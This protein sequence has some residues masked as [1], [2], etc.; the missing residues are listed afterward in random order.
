M[1]PIC[2]S[3]NIKSIG[4]INYEAPIYYSSVEIELSNQPELWC[5]DNCKSWFVQN[6]VSQ[7]DSVQLY[8]EGDASDRWGDNLFE[9]NHAED[10][11]KIISRYL[12]KGKTLLDIGCCDG[13]FLDYAHKK[14][15]ITY[16]IEYSENA[17][18]KLREKHH[19]VFTSYEEIEMKFDIVTAFDLAEHLYDFPN[20]ISTVRSKLKKDGVLL[21]IT[22][23]NCSKE[24]FEQKNDWWYVSF[25]E[26]IVFPSIDSYRIIGFNIVYYKKISPWFNSKWTISRIFR[27]LIL[28]L[29]WVNCSGWPF[30]Q[31]NHYI[32]ILKLD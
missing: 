20:W 32:I 19:S 16:G 2:S 11:V 12:G 6:I 26:H 18:N 7:K 23:D 8:T 1:C 28:T 21:I 17:C 5:C 14:G 27:N 30:A 9:Y 3:K 15:C 29:N 13:S 25:P 4:L 22:G 10:T 31:P 24:A